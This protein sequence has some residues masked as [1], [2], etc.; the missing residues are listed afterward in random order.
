MHAWNARSIDGAGPPVMCTV[1]MPRLA[2][3]AALVVCLT[4][5]VTVRAAL[6]RDDFYAAKAVSASE[7]WAVGNFGTIYHTADGGRTWAASASGV[8]NPLFGVD[9]ADAGH[10]WA[11]G[12]AA[13]IIHTADGGKTWQRQPA[14]IPSDKHLFAIKALDANTAW[15]LGDWGALTVTHDGGQTWEDRSIPDDV[16]LYDISFP[17][18]QHGFI[19][20][21]F[22]TVL[23]SSDGGQTWTKQD[24]GVEKTLFGISFSTPRTGWVVGIDGLVLRTRD[25]GATWE[26]Q[27]G[28]SAT[29]SVEQLS[30]LEAAKN[31][32]LY[33]V[34]VMGQ[35]GV[36]VGDSGTL[37]VTDDGGETWT[38]HD[39]PEKDRLTW[40]RGVSVVA[41]GHGFVV[42]AG[43]FLA[44]LDHADLTL[45]GGERVAR[46]SP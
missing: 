40:V 23:A 38:P 8:K 3:T 34:A 43:G 42:G 41:G 31:P 26:K 39:L 1:D 7:A 9:F 18:P 32:G 17:D 35:Y 45:P 19:A 2:L 37:L 44:A 33:S 27:R 22:G 25:G 20:G 4:F 36:V 12:R 30:F 46:L 14:S 21:E 5:P 11:V 13:L 29:E 6:I 24:V 16:V 15:A 28:T 10:G